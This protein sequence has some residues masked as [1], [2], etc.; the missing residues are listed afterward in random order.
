MKEAIHNF[1]S[2][3]VTPGLMRSLKTLVVFIISSLFLECFGSHISGAEISYRHISGQQYEVELVLYRDMTPGTAGIGNSANI[4]VTSSCFSPFNFSATRSN[5]PG[6][7]PAGDG[8]VIT[9]GF[10]EC[11]AFGI[12]APSTHIFKGIV[13][14]PSDCSDI[15]FSYSSCCRS[16]CID[17]LENCAPYSCNGNCPD[18]TYVEASLNNLL[19]D[20]STPEFVNP[21]L[22]A[23]CTNNSYYWNLGGIE[24]DGDSV[25]YSLVDPRQS[26]NG[27]LAFAPGF[28]ANH[29]FTTA[30]GSNGVTIDGQ[31]GQLIFTT[32]N[33][34][35]TSVLV[36]E[37]EE[38]R[39]I[40]GVWTRV[41]TSL[42]D[43]QISI[44][45][46]C[47]NSPCTNRIDTI[48]NPKGAY[49]NDRGC[50][51][52][53]LYSVGD[54]F[55]LDTGNTFYTVVD[56]PLLI[57]KRDNGD[58]LSKVCLSLVNIH[59]NN[60]FQDDSTFNQDISSWDVSNIPAMVNL[61]NNATLFDQDIGNWDVDS[62]TN[63][64]GLF[65]GASSFDQPIGNWDV[66]S[67]TNMVN[68]FR[69]ADGFDQDIGMW[70]VSSATNMKNMFAQATAFNQDIS[71]W[72]VGNATNMDKMFNGAALFS[73]DLSNWCVPSFAS[74]PANFSTGSSLNTSQL[75]VWGTC[76]I[77][78]NPNNAF[79][80]QRGCVVCDQYAVADSFS[81]DS[82]ASWYTV[83]DSALLAQK[84][85][86]GHDLSKVCVS[87]VTNMSYLFVNKNQ[88]D[89]DIGSWDVS[90]V[91][92]M[93]GTFFNASSFNQDIGNWD[94]SNVTDMGYA[95]YFAG[96]FN[97]DIGHW[98]VSNVN[99]MFSMFRSA[100]SFNQD[101]S[102][103]CVPNIPS[104]PNQFYL[105][106]GLTTTD[107]PAWGS[108]PCTLTLDLGPS[109]VSVCDSSYLLDAGNGYSS[110]LWNTGD[111]TQSI[112]VNA[113]GNYSCT[114]S[115]GNC[116]A[117]DSA[118]VSLLYAPI[119][120]SDSLVCPGLSVT[121]SASY[122]N[123][124]INYLWSTG[125]TTQ[126]ISVSPNQATTYFCTISDGQGSCI[127]SVFIDTPISVDSILA[128]DANKG[129][130]KAYF[131]GL[132]PSLSYDLQFKSVSDTLWRSK[133]IRAVSSGQ[134]KFNIIPLYNDNIDVRIIEVAGEEGCISSLVTPCKNMNLQLVE[135]KSAFCA[136]DSALVR[137]SIAGGFGAKSILWSNG[138][139]TKRPYA[140]QG[141]T[142][143]V[144]VTDASGCSLT[145]SITG[146]SLD[147]T[148]VP[149]N[150]AVSKGGPTIFLGS[151]TA[152]ALPAGATLIGYRMAYRI[153]GT[154]IWTNTPLSQN[155]PISVDF[156]GSGL[157]GG[158]YEFVA[159][160]RYRLNGVATNSNFTCRLAKGYN[161]VGGKTNNSD[162][163]ETG[164]GAVPTVVY[165]NP[166]DDF[167]YVQ[168]ALGSE[169]RLLDMQ[170]KM[171]TQ[172]ISTEL[173]TTLDLSA[174]AQGVY[175]LEIHSKGGTTTE[176]VVKR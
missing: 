70:D 59:L 163:S 8:G 11:V 171:I 134:Q 40:S 117:T 157:P 73:Q 67:V 34:Q 60:I 71:S 58:D 23:F 133:A 42:R 17:N 159:F 102:G 147:N 45:A 77:P 64:Q 27:I 158:N 89:Q 142:L 106:S 103:W 32:G 47:S 63:M 174:L 143:T 146:S 126:S 52:C 135:Q 86:D 141:E 36:L 175:M 153:R 81:L 13:S 15:V 22:K 94:V 66:S 140:Q 19:G 43:I 29:P 160:T 4:L 124:Q 95:F 12:I 110:Y 10:E 61:F 166:A 104:L 46:T 14:L 173:E 116:S 136:G 176:R 20:N 83:V 101:L 118:Y 90:N 168:A 7:T 82:G 2:Y 87:L 150:W 69:G 105:N 56:R 148:S 84:R 72:E 1:H 30:P 96:A 41:G 162:A 79:I 55:S 151:F 109:T 3:F 167:L 91:T 35:E 139:T 169:L 165:P 121:L 100:W 125:D 85:D 44:V 76:V 172:M 6:S 16:G 9:P 24:S 93:Q 114:V 98:D 138:A 119:T 132:N 115:D 108:C 161:G 107:L 5:P 51:V 25:F 152:P 50:V 31:A 164:I 145:D 113:T 156:T 97:Q 33:I 120:A 92:N 68:M 65:Y 122:S 39:K 170:G 99:S 48:Y 57:Q 54:T 127:D 155:T 21:G 28:S 80:N 88:F 112:R 53:D 137:V 129:V 37:A 74:A 154:Q 149:V 144:T 111:T 49:V 128:L 62:V 78:P 38:W 18:A 75:P 26:T 123:A 131:S 130:Y